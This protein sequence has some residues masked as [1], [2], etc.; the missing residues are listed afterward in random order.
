MPRL[1]FK[2]IAV[3][4]VKKISTALINELETLCKCPR[5]YFSIE[6]N[7]S[8]FVFDGEVIKPLAIT[9]VFW[10]DRGEEVQDRTAKIITKYMKET[11]CGDADVFFI[12]LFR[13]DYYENGEHF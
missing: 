8:D 9:E 6:V 11:G 4:D 12:K 5:Q 2:G 13:R 7:K 3:D 1:V 10:F